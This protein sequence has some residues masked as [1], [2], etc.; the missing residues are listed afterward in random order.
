MREWSGEWIVEMGL[1]IAL[2]CHH[3]AFGTK[4]TD[5]ARALQLDSFKKDN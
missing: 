2:P 3:A 4:V 5:G 1:S